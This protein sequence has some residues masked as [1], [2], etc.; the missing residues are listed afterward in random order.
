MASC[1]DENNPVDAQTCTQLFLANTRQ[2]LMLNQQMAQRH[3]NDEDTRLA[4]QIQQWNVARIQA[5]LAKRRM[6]S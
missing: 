5:R 3:P 4:V 6:S 2:D 1:S